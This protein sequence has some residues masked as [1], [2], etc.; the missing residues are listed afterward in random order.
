MYIFLRACSAP[1]LYTYYKLDT[2]IFDIYIYGGFIHN[3]AFLWRFMWF[4]DVF[5]FL[6]VLYAC[7]LYVLGKCV[8]CQSKTK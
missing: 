3:V 2:H 4:Y 7:D 6:V 1:I 5:V 8:I